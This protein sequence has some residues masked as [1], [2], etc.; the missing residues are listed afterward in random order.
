[1]QDFVQGS[2][3]EF[4]SGLLPDSKTCLSR[5]LMPCI[6]SLHASSSGKNQWCHLHPYTRELFA[7]RGWWERTA[8]RKQLVF[9]SKFSEW[10]GL[11]LSRLHH[12]TRLHVFWAWR[13]CTDP[14]PWWAPA[15][16]ALTG[17]S[18]TQRNLRRGICINLLL[19]GQGDTTE[20]MVIPIPPASPQHQCGENHTPYSN[21][22]RVEQPA[23]TL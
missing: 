9:L 18:A 8:A 12:P 21:K 22:K 14:S 15:T 2:T 11:L 6:S 20:V 7:G 5:L 1:M 3:R 13:L 19:Q 17:S 4:M 16:R 23:N 10:S